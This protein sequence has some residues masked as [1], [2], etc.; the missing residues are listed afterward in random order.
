MNESGLHVVGLAVLL[1]VASPV[2]AQETV[3]LAPDVPTDLAG[4]TYL[5]WEVVRTDTLTYAIEEMFPDGTAIAGLHQMDSGD[6]L[7]S[8]AVPT[9]LGGTRA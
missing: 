9:D 8:V 6:L 5:P 7:L 4:T 1:A 3:L 2:G